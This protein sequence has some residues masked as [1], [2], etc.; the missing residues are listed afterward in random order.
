MSIKH[1]KTLKASALSITALAAS[2]VWGKTPSGTTP[3]KGLGIDYLA[4]D[5]VPTKHVTVCESS[6]NKDKEFTGLFSDQLWIAV[7]SSDRKTHRLSFVVSEMVA[8]DEDRI[9]FLVYSPRTS[10]SPYYPTTE[11]G[12]E[13]GLEMTEY[14]VLGMYNIPALLRGQSP[15]NKVGLAVSTPTS[16]MTVH[17][18]FDAS[19]ID[20]MIRNSKETI[21]VQAALI[22]VSDL[23]AEKFENMILS[24]V[25]TL[26]FVANECPSETAYSYKADVSGNIT[27][28]KS[29]SQ[30]SS[31]NPNSDPN[32]QT[33]SF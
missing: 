15:E 7:D 13:L 1:Q 33:K 29:P 27:A 6:K 8:T 20:N 12:P 2:S 18:N 4:L 22:R 25:D 19:K 10:P 30:D 28:T 26:T 3:G 11:Y 32:P 21:H 5:E 16:K 24:E 31:A 14:E 17:F 23:E 9:L